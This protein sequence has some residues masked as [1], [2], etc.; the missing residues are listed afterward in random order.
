MKLTSIHQALI[1]A[2]AV[3]AATLF[4]YYWFWLAPMNKQIVNLRGI[5]SQK[6]KDLEDAKRTVAKYAEFKKRADSIQRELEWIQSRMPKSVD[7][8]RLLEAVNL[9]Q[10]RSGVVLTNFQVMGS[11]APKDYIEMPVNIKF[12]SDFK[13]FLDFLYQATLTDLFFTVKDIAINPW[14]DAMHP[15][16]SLTAQLTLSGV[17]SK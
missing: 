14:T 12:T 4:A 6:E 16:V 13:G 15:N 3:F 2:V 8:A 11:P 17:Q 7:Q 9:I 1:M 10:S 5:L